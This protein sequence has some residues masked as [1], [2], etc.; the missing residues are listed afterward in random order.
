MENLMTKDIY[1]E[2]YILKIKKNKLNITAQLSPLIERKYFSP[3]VY[4]KYLSLIL[5]FR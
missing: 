4:L 3:K 1:F 5:L 2:K